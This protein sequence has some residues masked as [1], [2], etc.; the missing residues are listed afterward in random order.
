[1]DLNKHTEVTHRSYSEGICG[2]L[3]QVFA[4]W[5]KFPINVLSHMH[6]KGKVPL[7]RSVE[8]PTH[9]T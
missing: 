9:L 6:N 3:C 4:C 7:G 5:Y 2:V 8:S 1:M